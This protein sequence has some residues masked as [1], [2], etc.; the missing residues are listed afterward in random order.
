MKQKIF[1]LLLDYNMAV[2]RGV[3]V[4]LLFPHLGQI[5]EKVSYE[6]PSSV[7][8]AEYDI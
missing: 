1:K 6:H 8:I 5:M 7:G 4:R 2:D 3:G